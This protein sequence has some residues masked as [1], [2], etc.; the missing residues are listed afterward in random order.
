[1]PSED[2]LGRSE[3]SEISSVPLPY[4]WQRTLTAPD[5]HQWPRPTAVVLP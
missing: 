5:G 2:R 1:M 3:N 4:H